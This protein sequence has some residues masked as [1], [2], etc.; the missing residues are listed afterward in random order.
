MTLLTV[1][2]SASPGWVRPTAGHC[3]NAAF[4]VLGIVPHLGVIGCTSKQVLS[5]SSHPL[6]PNPL[7]CYHFCIIN[8]CYLEHTNPYTYDIGDL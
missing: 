5:P 3:T 8:Y 7:P 2:L 4:I 1:V 6:T